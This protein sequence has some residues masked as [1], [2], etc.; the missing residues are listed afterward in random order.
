[1]IHFHETSRKSVFQESRQK[2]AKWPKP[3]NLLRKDKEI[4]LQ[5]TVFAQPRIHS[6]V[7]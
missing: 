6:M 1:M 3:K 7:T 4:H 5:I 2:P